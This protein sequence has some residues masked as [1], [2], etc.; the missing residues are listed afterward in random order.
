ME[1]SSRTVRASGL[2]LVTA[3]L[4]ACA[5][6]ADVDALDPGGATS[7]LVVELGR[8]T[9]SVTALVL[10]GAPLA[11]PPRAPS[12]DA[13]WVLLFDC[14]LASIG[15]APGPQALD[16]SGSTGRPL[17]RADRVL[18]D[19]GGAW[20]PHDA[21]PAELGA[22]R[23]ATTPG[24]ACT[25]FEGTTQL[26]AGTDA[27]RS[28]VL[29]PLPGGDVLVG[30]ERQA[31]FRAS[32]ARVEPFTALPADTV[33]LSGFIGPGVE[34]WIVGRGGRILR[35]TPDGGFVDAPAAGIDLRCVNQIVTSPET[36]PFE[37]ML[38]TC[39][40]EVVHFDGATWST[41]PTMSMTVLAGRPIAWVAPGEVLILGPDEDQVSWVTAAGERSERPVLA[42]TETPATV[43][44]SA[45]LGP[46]IGTDRG[47]LFRADGDR[48]IEVGRASNFRGVRGILPYEGGV[49]WG[50][51]GGV[52]TQWEPDAGRCPE[53]VGVAGNLSRTIDLEGSWVVLGISSDDDD[54]V[55]FLDPATADAPAACP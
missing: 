40:R 55:T 30:T 17:P 14:G 27:D 45:T 19:A 38:F 44:W 3:T 31:F 12:V 24:P 26:L 15:V 23:L 4:G 42:A 8:E 49:L 28:D 11:L 47:V 53:L 43:G 13:R 20:R 54:A 39:H 18:S 46:M 21:W 52:F 35:G 22:V 41:W 1:R 7:A 2:A 29:V 37:A 33:W 50:G 34:T 16:L 10:D 32:R 5:L 36:E 25:T 48:W 6:S 9:P 51:A